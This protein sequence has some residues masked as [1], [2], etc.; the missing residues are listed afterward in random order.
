MAKKFFSVMILAAIIF[1]CGQNNFAQAKDI[2]V[3][4]SNTTGRDCYVMTESIYWENYYICNATLKMVNPSTGNVKM[5]NYEFMIMQHWTD[6]KNS[7]G[8]S[9]TVNSSV[10]IEKAMWDFILDYSTKNKIRTR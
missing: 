2:Y 8:Y 3:G 9:G 7:Q 4:T 1:F 5:L 10:P 6:F